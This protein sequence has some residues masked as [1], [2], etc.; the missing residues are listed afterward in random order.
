MVV[1]AA[2]ISDSAGADW[3]LAGIKQACPRLTK[4]W[5]DQNYRGELV[6]WVAETEGVT[7][8]AV[9]KR[10][11]Q[12]GFAVQP[13]RWVVER[14]FAWLGRYRRLS[15]DYE[16][17]EAFSE[18]MVYLA[19]IGRMLDHLDRTGRENERNRTNYRHRAS[20]CAA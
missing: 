4:I 5:T 9:Q 10:A 16:H 14:T 18:S 20:R 8:E 15:K 7:L 17:E 2:D 1:H 6:V 11:D 19:S 3:V 12:K 13:R